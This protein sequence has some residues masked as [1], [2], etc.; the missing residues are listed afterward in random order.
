MRSTNSF[1]I[2]L[3][4]A[5]RSVLENLPFFRAYNSRFQEYHILVAAID[6][7]DKR[8][9]LIELMQAIMDGLFKKKVFVIAI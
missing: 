5:R 8:L 1:F 7:E 6:D 9:P 4:F 2:G 3:K